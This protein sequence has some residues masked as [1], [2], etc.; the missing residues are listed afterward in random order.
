MCQ[1]Q[2]IAPTASH[3]EIKEDGFRGHTTSSHF[4]KYLII[5]AKAS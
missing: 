4:Q 2:T 3:N 1:S 5:H